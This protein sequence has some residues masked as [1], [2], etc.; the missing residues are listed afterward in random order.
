VNSS[1]LLEIYQNSTVDGAIADQ[2][3][4]SGYYCQQWQLAKEG[5]Q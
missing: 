5:I 1:K 4:S 3:A 2:W